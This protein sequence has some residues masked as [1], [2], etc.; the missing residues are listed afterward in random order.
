MTYKNTCVAIA[1]NAAT[2]SYGHNP[3]ISILREQWLKGCSDSSNGE[4]CKIVYEE[5]MP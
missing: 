3:N 5:C 4:R 1:Q 2:A